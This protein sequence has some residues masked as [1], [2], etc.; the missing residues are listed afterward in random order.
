VKRYFRAQKVLI[1]RFARRF[2]R[3]FFWLNDAAPGPTVLGID[4]DAGPPLVGAFL[5]RDAL[6]ERF[7]A[8]DDADNRFAYKMITLSRIDAP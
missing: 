2:L 8:S 1:S 5:L 7:M 6:G 3:E 4:V